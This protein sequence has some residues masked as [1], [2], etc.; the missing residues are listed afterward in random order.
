MDR[1]D[2]AILLGSM[3]DLGDTFARNRLMRQRQN[4]FD[5]TRSDRTRESDLDRAMREKEFGLRRE[6]AADA[7]AVRRESIDAQ[8]SHYA[9]TEAHQAQMADYQRQLLAAKTD[10]D[11][12]QVLIQMGKEGM[13]TDDGL[14]KM[15]EAMNQKF[16]QAGIRVQLFRQP[17]ATAKTPTPYKHPTTGKEFVTYGNTIL[18]ADA[19]YAEVSDVTEDALGGGKRTVTRKVPAGD[20]QREM[21]RLEQKKT[22]DANE[23]GDVTPQQQKEI[24][25]ILSSPVLTEDQMRPAPKGGVFSTNAPVPAVK[26]PPVPTPVTPTPEDRVMVIS[27]AG[28]RGSIPRAQLSGA[29]KQGYKLV[30]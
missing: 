6:D 20:L 16:G 28:K 15:S 12:F 25:A 8:K 26:Q 2:L 18:S 4:E 29:L 5:L 22:L 14:A 7:R 24:D 10:E 9:N 23:Q 3:D 19:P 11:K 1:R 30:Q 27:P 13:L 21:D 17:A